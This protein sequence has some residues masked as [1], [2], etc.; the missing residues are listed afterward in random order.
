MLHG[1]E[2]V[3]AGERP[4]LPGVDEAGQDVQQDGA[5]RRRGTGVRPLVE[6]VEVAGVEH[7]VILALRRPGRARV[8]VARITGTIRY[9]STKAPRRMRSRGLV[10]PCSAQPASLP[11]VTR[12]VDSSP[13]RRTVIVTL[14][15]G[16]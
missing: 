13:P 10:L 5:V 7:L 12:S 6:G 9:N 4:G 11:S 16:R 1:R 14:S 8:S 2:Q 3:V 15:P